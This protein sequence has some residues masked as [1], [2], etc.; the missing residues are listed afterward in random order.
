MG[1]GYHKLNSS[2]FRSRLRAKNEPQSPGYS[3][4]PSGTK[5]HDPTYGAGKTA[6]EF[7]SDADR[8]LCVFESGLTV[9]MRGSAVRCGVQDAAKK[10]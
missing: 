2:A 1:V 9:T 3:V 10:D 6:E 7:I 8:V 5:I 4:I